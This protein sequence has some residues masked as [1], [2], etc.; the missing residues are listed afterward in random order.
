MGSLFIGMTD[1]DDMC[2]VFKLT[3][4]W[5]LKLYFMLQGFKE[6]VVEHLSWKGLTYFQVVLWNMDGVRVLTVWTVCT[7]FVLAECAT[8]LENE[9][10]M[11]AHGVE[12]FH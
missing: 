5:I 6:M 11:L 12:N 2:N 8:G 3:F 1:K 4:D 10:K 7:L 9:G